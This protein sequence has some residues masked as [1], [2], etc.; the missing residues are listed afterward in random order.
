MLRY[1]LMCLNWNRLERLMPSSFTDQLPTN[2]IYGPFFMVPFFFFFFF[3]FSLVRAT[4]SFIWNTV[5]LVAHKLFAAHNKGKLI[6]LTCWKW[7]I[8]NTPTRI[9]KNAQIKRHDLSSKRQELRNLIFEIIS[10][11]VVNDAWL[12][13][14]Y[15]VHPKIIL[16]VIWFCEILLK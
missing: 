11:K 5:S 13:L 12:Q 14:L 1:D 2:H 9:H 16:L 4:T 3:V 8:Q 10:V 7:H 15:M 6:F